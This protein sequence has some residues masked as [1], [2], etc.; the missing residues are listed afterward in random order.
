M[1]VETSRARLPSVPGSLYLAPSTRL[2]R[3]FLR[4]GNVQY[5]RAALEAFFFWLLPYLRNCAGIFTDT[6]SISS[7]AMSASRLLSVYAEAVPCPVE[8]LSQYHDGSEARNAEAG[9]IIDRIAAEARAAGGRPDG[10]V[11]C[12]LSATHSGRLVGQLREVLKLRGD[13]CCTEHSAAGKRDRQAG[14]REQE[15]P[16]EEA[17]ETGCRDR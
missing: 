15:N 14:D 9:E 13:P 7:I 2:M 17:D 3:S 8:M 11:V 4:V 6:W 12:L 5:S 1:I 16:V 10:E